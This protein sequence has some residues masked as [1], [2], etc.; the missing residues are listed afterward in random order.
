MSYEPPTP[1]ARKR[2]PQDT[3]IGPGGQ[4]S[5]RKPYRRRR[6]HKHAITSGEM[7][8]HRFKTVVAPANAMFTP[9]EALHESLDAFQEDFSIVAHGCYPK[10]DGG[11]D[12]A[13]RRKPNEQ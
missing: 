3:D 10:Q 9:L 1:T 4:E 6:Y 2:G 12:P 7:A 5:L 13:R 11:T 8:I